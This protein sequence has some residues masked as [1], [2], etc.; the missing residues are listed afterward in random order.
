[1]A[2][3]ERAAILREQQRASKRRYMAKDGPRRLAYAKR[4]RR[5]TG[6]AI[7]WNEMAALMG[8]QHD[9]CAICE[10]PISYEPGAGTV[11]NAH[12]DH[13]HATSKVRGWLCSPCNRALGML[14]DNA[15]TM[16]RAAD[17]LDLHA[18]R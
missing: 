15:T 8:E 11:A 4:Y 10:K 7:T 12:L 16:R 2:D 17:Y 18:A 5:L 1:M 3:P 6:I 9:R 14:G 13:C